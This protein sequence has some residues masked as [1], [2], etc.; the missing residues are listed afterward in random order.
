MYWVRTG[1]YDYKSEN[2]VSSRYSLP[3]TVIIASGGD[4]A[5]TT[6]T[7]KFLSVIDIQTIYCSID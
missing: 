4:D 5:S 3:T 1:T 2:T 7:I 6:G